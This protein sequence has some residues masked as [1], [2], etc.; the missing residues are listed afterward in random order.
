MIYLITFFHSQKERYIYILLHFLYFVMICLL[1]LKNNKTNE[2][3]SRMLV[4]KLII[5]NNFFM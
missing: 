1:E 2:I 5:V 3:V 4:V